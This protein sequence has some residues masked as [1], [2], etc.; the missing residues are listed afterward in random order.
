MMRPIWT[1]LCA[2]GLVAGATLAGSAPAARAADFLATTFASTDAC[3]ARRYDAAHLARNPAQ[4]VASIFLVPTGHS[5]SNYAAILHLG[6]RLKG[7]PALYDGFAYCNS[8]GAGAECLMEGDAGSLTLSPRQGGLRLTVG[9]FLVVE[10]EAGFSPDLAKD[11][12][13]RVFH[14]SAAP[15]GAC[16]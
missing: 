12:D 2:G 3:F 11:G 10:G 9:D 14:L 6:F 4:R 7:S 16:R 15:V 5:D 8:K 1:I 13:D